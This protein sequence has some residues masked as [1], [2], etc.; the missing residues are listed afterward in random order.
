M[1]NRNSRRH[2]D[3]ADFGPNS[4]SSYDRYQAT[5]ENHSRKRDSFTPSL[6]SDRPYQRR[7][8]AARGGPRGGYRGASR[9]E[10]RGGSR[11]GF[12]SARG[13]RGAGRSGYSE[14][15]VAKSVDTSSLHPSWQAKKQLEE[16]GKLKF[17]GTKVKFDD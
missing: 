5:R 12:Q 7:D 2:T 10:Y 11:G 3:E 8:F 9:G 15:P 14:Q 16:R 6:A 17:Q 13:G 4:F 1:V